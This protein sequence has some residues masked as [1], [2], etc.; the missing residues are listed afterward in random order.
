MG[1]SLFELYSSS[2]PRASYEYLKEICTAHLQRIPFE[3]IST[4]LHFKEYHRKGKLEPDVGRF[5]KQLVQQHMGGTCY[6]INS[7]LHQLLEQLGFRSRYAFLGGGHVALLV[8][9][10]NEKEEVY[11][12]C[13]NG[14]PFFEPVRLET[15]HNNVSQYG[16]IEVKLRP[17][18]GP[19]TYTYYRYVDGKLLTD[20]I[21]SFDIKKTYQFEDFQSAIKKYFQPN[22]LFTSNLRCQIWQ[23]EQQ[24]SLSLVNNILSIRDIDGKVE[25]RI[26]NDKYE[27]KDVIDHEFNLPKLP[28]EEALAVLQELDIDI[29]NK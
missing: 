28:V 15:D 22:D 12:D 3:N 27:L 25:K 20:L 26:L 14:A 2:D 7:S 23:L 10:P 13:G 4:M 1:D 18:D 24:R 9:L 6:M 17:G 16:D 21:W 5:V 8:H 19:G 11:I 29:F